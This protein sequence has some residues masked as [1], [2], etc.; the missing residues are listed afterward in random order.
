M[1]NNEVITRRHFILN[2]IFHVNCFI[3]EKSEFLT[4]REF[5]TK[6]YIGVDFLSYH[7]LIRA[8]GMHKNSL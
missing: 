4:L 5:S 3:K 7:G 2:K 1:I 6:F 8:V